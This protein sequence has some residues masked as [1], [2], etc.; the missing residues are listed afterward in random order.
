MAAYVICPLLNCPT[1]SH[2]PDLLRR[3]R[4]ASSGQDLIEY[5]LLA[6]F[7]AVAGVF[8][9]PEIAVRMDA[10]FLG[11]ETPVYDIWVPNDPGTP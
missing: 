5:A 10:I 3:L 1:M 8:A 9:W 4:R 11:W 2:I 6:A 7:I